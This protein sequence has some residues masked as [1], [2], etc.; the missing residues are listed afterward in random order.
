[1][2]ALSL[3][4]RLVLLP[5]L[6]RFQ[7]NGLVLAGAG[8]GALLLVWR[9]R[10]LAFLILGSFL[11]HVAVTLTYDAP[12]TVEYAMPAYLSL[13]ILVAVAIRDLLAVSSRL[14]DVRIPTLSFRLVVGAL[15]R[16]AALALLAA[17]VANLLSH[18]PSYRSLSRRHDARDYAQSL[19]R[20]AP[21]GAIILSNWH[22]FTSLRYVQEIEGVRDD[23][24][25]EYVVPGGEPLAQTWV[26]SVEEY[27]DRR[28]VVVVRFFAQEYDPLPYSFE[29]LGEAFLVRAEP[30]RDLPAGFT[31]LNAVLGD[32]MSVLGYRVARAGAQPAQPFIVELAWSP[33]DVPAAAVALFAQLIGPDGALWSTSGDPRHPPETLS[34]GEIII[35]RFVVYPRL[36]ASPGDYTLVVGAYSSDGRWKTSD[37]SDV[38]A[39]E[40]VRLQPSTTRPVTEHRRFIRLSGGPTLI[41]VDYE[42]DLE[43]KVRTYLHWAGPGEVTQ[44]KLTGAQGELISDSTVPELERGEY[45]TVAVDRPDVASRLSAVEQGAAR[46]WN[47]FFRREVR[48]PSPDPGERYVPFGDAL[49]LTRQQGPTGDLQPGTEATISLRF[50]S[51]RPLQRD[52]VVSTSLTSLQ[53]DGT[54]AWRASHDTVPALGAIPTLKWIRASTV[55]DPHRMAVPDDAA[56]LPAT[57]SV[58]VYDHFT[59]RSLPNLDQRSGSS[60]EIGS[61]AVSP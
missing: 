14:S 46:R 35:E 31:A 24:T 53:S 44:L 28:S 30:R 39:L 54:W 60:V 45:A 42:T 3:F 18:Y 15:P 40:T 38:V 61:W 29:P 20:D 19:L 25:V 5:T 9:D 43:G 34:P 4:D 8:I 11:V 56:L 36:H 49:V 22:W 10:K 48:L 55:L 23:V 47:L 58:L 50:R 52:Y 21:E 2:F 1:M 13:S 41:G 51:Q 26:R 32:R 37:G 59:Q 7:F 12:Q 33:A 6:L 57:G 17:V 27:V 16:I